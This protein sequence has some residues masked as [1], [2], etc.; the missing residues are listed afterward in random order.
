MCVHSVLITWAKPESM[1]RT[2]YASLVNHS[3]APKQE[4]A[5]LSVRTCIH[6]YTRVH[7]ILHIMF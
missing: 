2:Y 5:F 6:T 3:Q 7:N 4:I 1:S